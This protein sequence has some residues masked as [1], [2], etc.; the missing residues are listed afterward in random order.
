MRNWILVTSAVLTLV[1]AGCSLHTRTAEQRVASQTSDLASHGAASTPESASPWWSVFE[2]EALG[3]WM[4]RAL[5]DE[6]SRLVSARAGVERAEAYLKAQKATDLPGVNVSGSLGRSRSQGIMGGVSSSWNLSLASSYELDLWGK[7][8]AHKKQR[9]LD[10]EMALLSQRLSTISL[11]ARVADTWYLLKERT[12]QWELASREAELRK[13]WLDTVTHRYQQGVVSVSAVYGARSQLA[14]TQAR[15]AALKGDVTVAGHALSALANEK[16]GAARIDSRGPLPQLPGLSTTHLP[17]ELVLDRPDV[18]LA[19]AEV[20]KADEAVAVSF[21]NRFP[22][23]SLTAGYGQGGY[24]SGGLDGSGPAWNIGGNLLAPLLDWGGRKAKVSADKA[25]LTKAESDLRTVALEAFQ[26]AADALIRCRQAEESLAEYQQVLALSLSNTEYVK[27]RYLEGA[28]D[29][30]ELLEAQ[31]GEV[32]ARSQLV[33]AKR[34]V[35]STRISLA[36]ALALK[37]L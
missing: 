25:S 31:M 1:M 4:K 13:A 3:H 21:A 11:S 12:S 19:M 24:D 22:S 18:R 10:R 20:Q 7:R 28:S 26:E 35:I 29:V 30:L 36:R 2:D 32:S 9:M 33:L 34:Q 37:S 16:P 14:T 6:N 5:T 27:A 8:A 23:F 17:S 15:V